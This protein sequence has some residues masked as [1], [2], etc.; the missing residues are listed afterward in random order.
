MIRSASLPLREQQGYHIA[1][2]FDVPPESLGLPG[3][4]DVEPVAV[5]P[6]RSLIQRV[7]RSPFARDVRRIGPWAV[8]AAVA[9]YYLV[10]ALGWLLLT[11]ALGL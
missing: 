9:T 4:V 5:R 10:P 11:A 6:H 2:A 7:V 3:V 8:V 1:R